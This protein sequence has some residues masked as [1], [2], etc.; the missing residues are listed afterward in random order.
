MIRCSDDDKKSRLMR[1]KQ[2]TRIRGLWP[3]ICFPVLL[4]LVVSV[5]H[6]VFLVKV[7]YTV[8]SFHLAKSRPV[9]ILNSFVTTRVS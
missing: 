2:V 5:M 7:L 1:G 6:L 4:T 3:G 8:S 9:I